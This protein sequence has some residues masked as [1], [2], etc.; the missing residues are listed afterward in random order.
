MNP[1]V[2]R[3][4]ILSSRDIFGEQVTLKGNTAETENQ[5]IPVKNTESVDNKEINTA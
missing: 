2:Y 5:I 4:D 3:T 1:N